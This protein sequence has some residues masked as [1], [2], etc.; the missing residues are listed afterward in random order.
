MTAENIGYV[1]E[2]L[3]NS[4]V[5]DCWT[6]NIGMKKNRPGWKIC[7]L[8]T[9][10]NQNEHLNILFQETTTIGIRIH[11]IERIALQRKFIQLTTQYG[12][13][14]TK[15]SLLN[16]KIITI[17]PEYDDCSTIALKCKVPLKNIQSEVMQLIA[18]YKLKYNN[19][20]N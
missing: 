14:N 11:S 20:T 9:K 4:N 2:L 12:N 16:G 1:M 10:E 15:V 8:T 3:I 18:D 6:E 19:E 13:I 7:I 5:N 17:K